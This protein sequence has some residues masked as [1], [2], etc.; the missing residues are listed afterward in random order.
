MNKIIRY[1]VL[2]VVVAA[3]V[4]ASAKDKSSSP[5]LGLLFDRMDRM[6]VVVEFKTS[7][8]FMGQSEDIEERVLGL[9]VEPQGMI[10]F[11]GSALS[12]GGHPASEAVGGLRVEKPK[13]I[14]VTDSQGNT[15]DAEY[16][17]VDTYSLIAFCRLP[18]S[19]KTAIPAA[20]FAKTD[21]KLGEQVY[22]F[23]MLPENFA[24]RFQMAATVITAVLTKP[25]AFYLT[26]ELTGSFIASPVVS[27]DGSLVGVVVP[28]TKSSARPSPYDLNGPADNPVGIM[29]LDR[30]QALLDKPPAPGEYKRG[31][32]GISL[33]A[34]DPD[35]AAFWNLTITGG[36]IVSEVVP[37]SPAEAAALQKGD[38][39]V[40]VDDVPLDIKDDADLTVFQKMIS[41]L[42]AQ[43]KMALTVIR[44]GD[45]RNDTLAITAVLGEMPVTAQDA[46]SYEDKDFD[47]TLRDLVFADFNIRDLDPGE[48]VGVIVD[49]EESGGWAAV[50]GIRPGDIITKINDRTVASVSESKPIFADLKQA[51]M[52]DVVFMVWRNHKTLFVNVKTHWK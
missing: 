26:G 38:F 51:K 42:G 39:I 4:S 40:A 20:R 49:K 8:S 21:V 35:I 11:D 12:T 45:N 46:P 5:D 10:I 29:P 18:D 32:L 25:E 43:G 6:L 13:A 3:C 14:T 27:A 23:W 16:I 37:H 28:V 17:G 22:M 34:L 31:W 48:V 44:P 24:P 41:E 50:G 7:M 30:F 33:Q 36:V 15:Y 2:V 19:V 47:L 9:S 52:R 1:V